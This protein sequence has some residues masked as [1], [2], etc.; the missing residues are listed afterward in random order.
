MRRLLL[1]EDFEKDVNQ[2]ANTAYSLGFEHIDARTSLQGARTYLEHALDG[3]SPLPDAIVLDL[4]LG[5]DS[6]YELL[7]FWHRTPQ[8]SKIP[9][10]VWS[11]LGDEQREMCNLFKVS[12]FVGKWEGNEA[13]REALAN[14]GNSSNAAQV[15][16][17]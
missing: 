12:A 13:L 17:K 14:L 9:L 11:I 6:G 7:R 4:N 2:A 16:G 15:P 3:D 10:I 8:L 5:Y 1:V